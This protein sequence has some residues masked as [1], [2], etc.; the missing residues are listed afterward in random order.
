MNGIRIAAGL[1]VV[2][3]LTGACAA[4]EQPAE[5]P[6]AATQPPT[7]TLTPL[8]QQALPNAPGKTFTSSIVDFPP[9]ARATPHRH[10]EAFVYAYV[11]EGTLRS[12]LDDQ[13]TSTYHQGQNWVEQPGAH[14]VLTENASRTDRA[15][16]LV[17]FVSNTGDALKVDDPHP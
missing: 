6:M 5:A 2:A 16:L 10:G 17:V 9:G 1:L 3:A 14:H 7:E 11:L 12:Q 4:P 15:K 13:P 8:L